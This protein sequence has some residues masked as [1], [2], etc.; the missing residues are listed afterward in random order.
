MAHTD[1]TLHPTAS[2]FYAESYTCG[3]LYHG[4]KF[5][6]DWLNTSLVVHSSEGGELLREA[7]LIAPQ[8]LSPERLGFVGRYRHFGSVIM[9]APPDISRTLYDSLTPH[10]TPSEAMSVSLLRGDVGVVVRVLTLS[11]EA[12]QK[13]T[14][15]LCSSFRL[16]IKGCPLPEEFAWR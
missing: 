9:M 4:E 2:L 5:T 12:L 11:T 14:R 3:R 6:Y 8:T 16:L 15:S 10:A 7:M 1:I 13:R